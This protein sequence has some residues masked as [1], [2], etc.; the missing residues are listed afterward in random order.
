MISPSFI[1]NAQAIT[2]DNNNNFKKL[3]G[4][5]VSIKY[6]KCNN[7]NVNVNGFTLDLG[8]FPELL[9]G[10][11]AATAETETG[12]NSLGSKGGS[13]NGPSGSTSGFVFVCIN[14]NNNAGQGEDEN[15]E[16]QNCEDCF[17]VLDETQIDFLLIDV[18]ETSIEGFC[19]DLTRIPNG[20]EE[21]LGVLNVLDDVVHDITQEEI[22]AII[23]CLIDTG[24]IAPLIME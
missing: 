5:D 4:I 12:A 14:N 16:P 20:N 6:V 11:V 21:T 24:V 10:E 3:F 2:M 23:A 22:D 18:E 13:N 19:E 8:A 9:G 17:S 7:I 1:N 15:G